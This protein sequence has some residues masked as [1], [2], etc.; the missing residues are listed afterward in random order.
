MIN[1]INLLDFDKQKMHSFFLSIGEKQFRVNQIMNW[2][3]KYYCNDFNKMTNLNLLL[4]NKLNNIACIYSPK[5]S[6][7]QISLDGTIKWSV[8]IGNKFIETVYIPEKKRS[9]ICVSS[10]IGCIL[11]CKFCSTGYQGFNGNLSVSEIV[12]QIW[13]ASR[14]IKN[15]TGK[16]NTSITNIVFMGMGEPLLNIKNLI[17]AL[18]IITDSSSFNISK[19]RVTVSTS[20]IVPGLEI[21]RSAIDVNLAISLHASNDKIRNLIM[22]INKKYS[23][24]SILSEVRKYLK[25]STANHGGV[26]VEYV[27]LKNI[28]DSS[29]NAKELAVLLKNTPSKINLIPWN[30]FI[31]TNYE[32]SSYNTIEN[33]SKILRKKGFITTIRKNRGKDIKAACGQLAGKV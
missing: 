5:F 22:P 2:I 26:T 8:E 14:I 32:S 16:K 24:K 3:Y 10:Q 6:K 18:K 11:K 33:F 20:G 28:N 31:G 1:K 29:N 7:E 17:P 25:T 4:R 15:Q 21:L 23:I 13:N 9:T 19:R 12:G 27:M 30:R